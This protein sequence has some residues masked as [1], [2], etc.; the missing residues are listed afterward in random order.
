MLRINGEG[1]PHQACAACKHQRR[2]CTPECPLAP[3]FPAEKTTI[4]LA[5]QKVFGVSNIV[6]MLRELDSHEKRQLAINSLCWEA[7]WRLIEPTEGCFGEFKRM[8]EELCSY[9]RM[10]ETHNCSI[11]GQGGTGKPENLNAPVYSNNNINNSVANN[12]N[13]VLTASNT[14][15]NGGLNSVHELNQSFVH[16]FNKDNSGGGQLLYQLAMEGTDQQLFFRGGLQENMNG[17]LW[18]GEGLLKKTNG[19]T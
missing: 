12:F 9:K 8:T 2:K 15:N 6:K 5:V 4:F 14:N 13:G 7:Q 1:S 17:P 11:K 19:R 3:F 16:G 18:D 10:F